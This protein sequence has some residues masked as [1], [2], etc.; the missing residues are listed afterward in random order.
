MLFSEN[1]N[2][3]NHLRNFFFVSVNI[4]TLAVRV[5][6]AK[7]DSFISY[8]LYISVEAFFIS[9]PFISGTF[10]VPQESQRKGVFDEKLL[11]TGKIHKVDGE[12]SVSRNKIIHS[13]NPMRKDAD[14]E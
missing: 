8:N 6:G 7:K 3:A 2:F 12:R 4:H 5:C 9:L 11:D 1:L 13:V 14:I 10:V